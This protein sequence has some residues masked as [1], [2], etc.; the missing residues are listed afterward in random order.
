MRPPDPVPTAESERLRDRAA[1]VRRQVYEMIVGAGKGHIGGS[2][3]AVDILVALYH[4]GVLRVD[5]RR[6]DWPDRDRLVYS[7]GHACEALYAVLADAGFLAPST[8]ATYGR[9][10][11][12]LGGHVDRRVPGVDVSTG[13][14]GHG[15][16]IGAGLAL[17]AKLDGRDWRTFVLLGDGECYEGSVWEAATFAAH[18]ELGHLIAIVDRNGKITLEPT[19]TC[20]RLEPFRAKWEAFGWDV[21]ETD[22]HALDTLVP[23][24]RSARSGRSVRPIVVLASTVKGKGIGFM[25]TSCD[26]HHAVPR[27][28]EREAAR[29]ELYAD[30]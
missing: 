6:P 25:E 7:K 26:W 11:T 2:L 21:V 20:N 1:W 10:G 22:G 27:G 3:S 23:A 12:M 4:G 15:L 18:H 19:E 29:R 16:G 24:L 28:A 9:P 17:A 5:P 14:L 30:A 13:S 8:L